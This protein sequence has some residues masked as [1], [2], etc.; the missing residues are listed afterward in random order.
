ML[1][2]LQVVQWV[3][4]HDGTNGVERQRD[5]DALVG[6]EWSVNGQRAGGNH[7]ETGAESKHC[8]LEVAAL[9]LLICDYPPVLV[10]LDGKVGHVL[11][12]LVGEAHV[13]VH[14]ALAAREGARDLQ[15]LCLHCREPHLRKR[16]THTVCVN[17][18]GMAEGSE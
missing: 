18:S 17:T 5:L 7:P 10:E 8:W 16:L 14:V 11:Q 15:A 9:P 6:H 13:H 2:Y 4:L 3:H 1:Q 12:S